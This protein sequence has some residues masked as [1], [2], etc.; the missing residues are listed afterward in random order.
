MPGHKASTEFAKKFPNSGIDITELSYSDNLHCPTG[1]IAQ[2]QRDIA[3][4]LGADCSYITTDGSTSG[5]FTLVYA[6]S[7]QGKGLILP[8]N[9]HASAFNACRIL[10]VD[11]VILSGEMREGILLP[12]DIDAVEAA[13]LANDGASLLVTS[14]DYYGNIAQLEAYSRLCKKYNRLLLVDGAHG[15]HLAV[16]EEKRL[17]AGIYA[18]VWVDGAHKTLPTLTQ[19]AVISCKNAC[20]EVVEEALGL[21]RTTSP[22]YPIMASVEYGVKFLESSENAI[23]KLKSA[24]TELKEELSNAYFYASEDWAKLVL[25]CKATGICPDYL[26]KQLEARGYFIE[27]NDGRYLLFYLSPSTDVKSLNALKNELKRLLNGEKPEYRGAEN[28]LP[29]PKGRTSYLNALSADSESVAIEDAEGRICAKNVGITPP[30][31]PVIIA[32]DIISADQIAAMRTDKSTFGL[33]EG[34]IRVVKR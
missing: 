21:F 13:M 24:I 27:M 22:S 4:I 9:A 20:K 30:C 7:K 31:V 26:E 18:D 11:P 1:V 32:G 34:K 33:E 14:P 15:S 17:H 8:R 25:D 19:G 16:G 28:T 12:P 5:V 3:K 6:A 10:G 23:K 2:A 29:N